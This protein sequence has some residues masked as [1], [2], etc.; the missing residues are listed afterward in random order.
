MAASAMAPGIDV[1]A[2]ELD[3]ARGDLGEVEHV[4]D[5]REQ[6]PAAGVDVADV[7]HLPVVQGAE[8]LLLEQLGEAD[9]R[10]ERRAQLVRHAGEEAGLRVALPLGLVARDLEQLVDAAQLVVLLAEVRE[11]GGAGLG[12]VP[13]GVGLGGVELLTELLL[14][15]LTAFVL[16]LLPAEQGAH[17]RADDVEPAGLGDEVVRAGVHAGDHCL[18]L[19]ERRHD[20]DGG[21]P[22]RRHLLDLAA[23]VEAG[24]P[25]EVDLEQEAVERLDGEELECGLARRRDGDLVP[26]PFELG[27]EGVRKARVGIDDEDA[28]RAERARRGLGM[29]AVRAAAHE[30]REAREDEAGVGAAAHEGV[31]PGFERAE[32]LAHVRGGGQQQRRHTAERGV[33]PHTL[34]DGRTVYPRQA[35]AHDGGGGAQRE[36]DPEALLSGRGEAGRV[37]GLLQHRAQ[38]GAVDGAVLHDEHGAGLDGAGVRGVAVHELPRA[39]H[40][41]ASIV[42]FPDVVVR[43]DRPAADAVAHDGLGREQHDRGRGRGAARPLDLLEKIHA[44]AVREHDVEDHERVG[45]VREGDA[46]LGEGGAK[47]DVEARVHE[48]GPEVHPHGEAVVHDEHASGHGLLAVAARADISRPTPVGARIRWAA[49]WL[50]HRERASTTNTRSVREGSPT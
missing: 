34:H 44:V 4:V 6:V 45:L 27:G 22:P 50:G 41:V 15:D 18:L 5:E 13:G 7:L 28:L 39:G 9:D 42:G 48:G 29:E 11:E 23:D 3:A 26:L 17:A 12:E 20:D 35:R 21:V 40:D 31:H 19:L 36:G 47:S 30:R 8:E 1:L 10:V 43:P 46:P 25:G 37:A 49:I 2:F 38:H 14:L 33:Q 16:E 32:L 24:A